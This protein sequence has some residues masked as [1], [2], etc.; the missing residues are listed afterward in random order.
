MGKGIRRI[1]KQ[2]KSLVKEK[3]HIELT[4]KNET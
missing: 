2:I 1:Y 4:S 3:D